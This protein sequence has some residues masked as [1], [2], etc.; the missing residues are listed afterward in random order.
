[1]STDPATDP[2]ALDPAAL[3]DLSDLLGDDQAALAE[4]VDAFVE[5]APLRIAEL[6]TG[7]T[8]GDAALVGRAAH[9]LKANAATFGARSLESH[10]RSLEETARNGDL[11]V[12][13]AAVAAVESSWADTEPLLLALRGRAPAA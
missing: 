9:T 4:I 7:V 11:T 2:A 10:S 6:R 12:A 5:E 1:M 13:A 8:A 3:R